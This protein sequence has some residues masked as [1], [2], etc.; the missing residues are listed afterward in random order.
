MEVWGLDGMLKRFV[1]GI[2]VSFV[3]DCFNK[4]FVDVVKLVVC[5]EVF[6][7]GEEFVEFGFDVLFMFMCEWDFCVV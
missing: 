6:K 4:K 7:Y 3:V 5:V 2:C 1:L